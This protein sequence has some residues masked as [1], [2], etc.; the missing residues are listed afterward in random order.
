MMQ[1]LLLRACVCVR[2]CVG[3]CGWVGGC[4]R[5]CV[6]VNQ[7]EGPQEALM[8]VEKMLRLLMVIEVVQLLFLLSCRLLL[9]IDIVATI[10]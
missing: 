10:L 7:C 5:A 4:V 1:L 3:V 6:S 2:A 8:K 9:M